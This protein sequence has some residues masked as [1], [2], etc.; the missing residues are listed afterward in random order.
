MQC[1][2]VCASTCT[3]HYFVAL[4]ESYSFSIYFHQSSTT[5]ISCNKDIFR[6]FCD[7]FSAYRSY[8]ALLKCLST[9]T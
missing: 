8:L 9:L 2:Y 1:I 5:Q 6:K 4:L 7:Y 3:I